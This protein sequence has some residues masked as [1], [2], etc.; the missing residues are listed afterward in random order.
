MRRMPA[1]R[2]LRLIS[3]RMTRMPTR[4]EAVAMPEPMSP[5]PRT[6]T[7]PRARGGTLLSSMPATFLVPRIAKNTCT[8]AECAG[9]AAAAL[10]AAVSACIAKGKEYKG[11][12]RGEKKRE[13]EEREERNRNK[14]VRDACQQMQRMGW[15]GRGGEGEAC[16]PAGRPRRP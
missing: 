10:K 11:E 6:A 4:R 2:N 7:V 9:S 16:S 8:S 12:E 1:S 3:L 13:G 5:P 15:D 14:M